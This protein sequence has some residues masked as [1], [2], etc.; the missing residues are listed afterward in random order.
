MSCVG[1]TEQIRCRWRVRPPIRKTRKI[2]A[3]QPSGTGDVLASAEHEATKHLWRAIRTRK[4]PRRGRK[5]CD[6]TRTDL[7][8]QR[9]IRKSKSNVIE[10]ERA[11]KPVNLGAQ[12]GSSMAGCS[13]GRV[14]MQDT[15]GSWQCD[16]ESTMA[17][18]RRRGGNRVSL[19]RG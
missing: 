5:I 16:R 6:G 11:S 7:W 3:L 17:H 19:W 9:P 13:G 10:E 15:R 14:G 4:R 8:P 18:E 2:K 1:A 12:D